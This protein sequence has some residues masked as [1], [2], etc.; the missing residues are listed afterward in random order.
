MIGLYNFIAY[1]GGGG[2]G[3]VW[4]K[5]IQHFLSDWVTE[6]TVGHGVDI[7]LPWLGLFGT[8][9]YRFYGALLRLY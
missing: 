9:G 1:G 2:G 5:R 6:T 4:R 8:L 3:G 7:P